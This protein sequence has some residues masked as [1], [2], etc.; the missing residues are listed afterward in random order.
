M[1][2]CRFL[3]RLLIS[4]STSCLSLH[5]CRRVLL[6]TVLTIYENSSVCTNRDVSQVIEVTIKSMEEY[7]KE[8]QRVNK[9]VKTF[10]ITES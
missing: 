8:F 4:F 6:S 7:V 1:S 3:C 2:L 10:K 9:V 5:P